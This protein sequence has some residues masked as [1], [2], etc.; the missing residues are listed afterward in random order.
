MYSKMPPIP[1]GVDF[2][3]ALYLHQMLP[4]EPLAALFPAAAAE[5]DSLGHHIGQMPVEGPHD[6]LDFLVILFRKRAA[7][8][9]ENGAAAVAEDA[10]EQPG[11]EAREAVMD[12]Q[13][14]PGEEAC[15]PLR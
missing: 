8:V 7:Q 2:F 14:Q 6:Q 1:Q 4:A 3:R 15:N 5:P 9:D 12:G 13:G 10:A 11:E